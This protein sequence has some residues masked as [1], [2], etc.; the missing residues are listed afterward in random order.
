MF[1]TEFFHSITTNYVTNPSFLFCFV[2]SRIL[3]VLY[4]V[5]CSSTQNFN[6]NSYNNKFAII[7]I[8]SYKADASVRF[9]GCGSLIMKY[10][11]N[12]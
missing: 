6:N 9:P 3:Q 2:H 7:T 4:Y 1:T 11:V 5:N 8:N 12:E 10:D